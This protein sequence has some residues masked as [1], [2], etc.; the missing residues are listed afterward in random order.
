MLSYLLTHESHLIVKMK[1]ELVHVHAD[2]KKSNYKFKIIINTKNEIEIH[3][4]TY[5]T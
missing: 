1:Y 4:S 3:L 2:L 5:C